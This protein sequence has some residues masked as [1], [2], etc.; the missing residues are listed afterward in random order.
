MSSSVSPARSQDLPRRLAEDLDGH[1]ERRVAVH[2]R[3][4]RSSW[5]AMIVSPMP[6]SEASRIGPIS[7]SPSWPSTTAPAP[8]P[9]SGG[10][11]LVGRGRRSREIVSA[12][13]TSTRS[14]RPVSIWA[15]PTDSADEPAGARGAD[16]ERADADAER[17]G[18][19]RRRVRRDLV[20]GHRRDQHEVD[21]GRAQAGVGERAAGGGQREVGGALVGRGVA[22][23]ADAGAADDPV[24]VDADAARRSG[25]SGRRGRAAGGRARGR[26]RCAR[27]RGGR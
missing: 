26:A 21:V 25:R 5:W 22:A 19:E 3:S 2:R 15:A 12:P 20:G 16:V 13:I 11:A 1:V 9:N 10:G 4:V 23:R 24:G 18:D 7:P 14:A 8:S 27:V 6:P 17:V